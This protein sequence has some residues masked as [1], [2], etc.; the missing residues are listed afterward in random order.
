M[1]S[2]TIR[3]RA[4]SKKERLTPCYR[5][6]SIHEDFFRENQGIKLKKSVLLIG[7]AG[8]I[9]PLVTRNLLSAGTSIVC[10]DLLCYENKE[11]VSEFLN[12]PDF[13]FIH[14]DLSDERVLSAALEGITDVVILAGLVGDPITKSFPIESK[15][16]N[17]LGI[18]K[19]IKQLAGRGIEKVVLIS[20]CSNYGMIP[21][22]VRADEEY[23][24]NPLSSYAR[25]KVSAEQLLL[26][27]ALKSDYSGVIL[28]FAT[29]FGVAPRTRFD[30]T[31]NQFTRELALKRE[32]LVF[33]PDTWRPYCHVEDFGRVVETVLFSS[34]DL[35]S[36]QIYNAGGNENIFTKRQIVE[37]ISKELSGTKVIF[38][39]EGSDPR[40]YR[41]DFSKIK[42]HLG[43]E[44]IRS[45]QSGIRELLKGFESGLFSDV[46][47]R[48]NF[49]GN[50]KVEYHS[51]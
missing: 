32:L 20:T 41:V 34:R 7:G 13:R 15:L 33:D 22:E 29:A 35:V 23:P 47:K 14:G 6:L 43:F 39:S 45:V 11:S 2:R 48:I 31:I 3:I 49:Y 10:L 18:Q 30:L 19:C 9:G 37:L 5:V 36:G 38:Q 51:P 25:D 16:I 28:R 46:E 42:E 26:S 44:P 24:L 27:E 40:N 50:Y 1:D 17:E 12:N 4:S 21:D 8:Y